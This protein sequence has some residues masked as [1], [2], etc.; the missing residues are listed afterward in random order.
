MGGQE[1][2][3]ALQGQ[4]LHCQGRQG[5]TLGHGTH[6]YFFLFSWAV[7]PKWNP[8][9]L[10]R[11]EVVLGIRAPVA[12]V[13]VDVEGRECGDALPTRSPAPRMGGGPREVSHGQGILLPSDA[14]SPSTGGRTWPAWGE[15]CPWQ[16]TPESLQVLGG[17]PQR[18]VLNRR[19][20]PSGVF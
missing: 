18:G 14:A 9:R 16:T 15:G 12:S 5:G 13:P 20:R 2:H 8:H 6:N 11:V 3:G 10:Q 4:D 17:S 7:G 19:A 1:G